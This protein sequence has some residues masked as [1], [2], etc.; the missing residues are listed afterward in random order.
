LFTDLY[1][2]RLESSKRIPFEITDG[3]FFALEE[4]GAI[5]VTG[6]QDHAAGEE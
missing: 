6:S 2:H 1:I 4:L 5:P 3:F